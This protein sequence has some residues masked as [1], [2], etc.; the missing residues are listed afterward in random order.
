MVAGQR[1]AAAKL[2]HDNAGRAGIASSDGG[3]TGCPLPASEKRSGLYQ[4]LVANRAAFL[5]FRLLRSSSRVLPQQ[6][7]G[8][9]K[10]LRDDACPAFN[11]MRD[12]LHGDRSFK[13]QPCFF[14]VTPA[15]VRIDRRQ[16]GELDYRAV[17]L[18]QPGIDPN[19]RPKAG[20]V[21]DHPTECPATSAKKR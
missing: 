2:M 14:A 16:V 18:C 10:E 8:A 20:N 19:S 12:D 11:P 1:N 15:N 5:V 4:L 21:T 17:S 7:S 13:D 3:Q 6:T 9:Q